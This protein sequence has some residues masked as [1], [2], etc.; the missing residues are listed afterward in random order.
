MGLADIQLTS[1]MRK[2][3]FSLKDIDAKV[4]TTQMRLA[5]GKK[6]NS[7]LDNPTNFFAAKT[8]FARAEDLKNKKDLMAE[9]IKT[10]EAAD[11]GIAAISSLIVTAKAIAMAAKMAKGSDRISL[12]AQ[13]NQIV[14]QIDTLAG[15]SGYRGANLLKSDTLQIDFNESGT[16]TLS[17]TG[18]DATSKG[19]GI[20][21]VR[22]LGSVQ[23]TTLAAGLY[24]SM[25]LK[26][27]G[28][29]VS[30]GYNHPSGVL[31][32]PASAESDVISI[33]S[34]GSFF[35]SAL[36]S[37]GSVVAW[38]SNV[39][40]ETTVP[41][42]AQTDVIAIAEGLGH[43]IA[44]RD[45]GMVVAWGD[46]NL[47]QTTVPLSAQSGVA[48]ISAGTNYSLALKEDGSVVAWGNPAFGLTSVPSEAASGVVSIAA[49]GFH[50]LALKSD[51]SVVAWGSNSDGQATVP[52]AA[53]SG[54]VAIAAGSLFSLALKEDGSVV[55]WGDATD[56]K[57]TVPAAA[58]SGVNAISAGEQHALA[59]KSDGSVIAWGSDGYG[60]ISLPPEA[61]S[62]VRLQK[63]SWALDA[64]ISASERQLEGAIS[65]LRADSVSLSANFSVI[66]VRQ[67]FT[68]EMIATLTAGAENLTLADMNEEGAAMLM[69]EAREQLGITSL[70]F[71]S[72]SAAS[73]MKLF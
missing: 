5:T 30:W 45:D 28:S 55:A 8:H 24:Y 67:D 52:A 57:T 68:Q 34:D 20:S 6:V 23:D 32:V 48:E 33:A 1:G 3:I 29:V 69:L 17:I 53:R 13:Y 44:L 36:K 61:Q 26:E 19:L 14:S 31:N 10:G 40:G 54:V 39:N 59:L 49:G 27:D 16:S 2:S 56:G 4:S 35:A 65:T 62:G 51:G 15:D 41:V 66:A 9:A 50:A 25:A 42:A 22:T 58:L 37:D 72:E 73:V 18:V 38:G 12:A 43:V 63:M 47:G 11:S 60:E 46:N 21:E 7:P 64:G 71:G 70:S